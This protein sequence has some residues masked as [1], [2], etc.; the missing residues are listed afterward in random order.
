MGTPT[1]TPE[2]AAVVEKLAKEYRLPIRT[3]GAKRFSWDV[4]TAATVK[5]REKALVEAI[6]KLEP[7][8]WILVEH[9]GLDN[10]E[11][12]AIGHDGYWNVASH[13]DAVTKAFTSKKV[14]AA[15]KKKNV[16]LVSYGDIW[17]Y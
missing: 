16:Q 17:S 15:I 8:V 10:E 2:L 12:R 7:G 3:P 1:S 14:K 4:E 6:E 11:M 13:R 5:E 9:P